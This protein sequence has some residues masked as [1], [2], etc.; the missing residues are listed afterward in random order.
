MNQ[1]I[2]RYDF[3]YSDEYQELRV[4]SV[5][6]DDRFSAV[7]PMND[8]PDS[9]DMDRIHP[10]ATEAHKVWNDNLVS[11]D[12]LIAWSEAVGGAQVDMMPRIADAPMDER[13]SAIYRIIIGETEVGKRIG[14]Q[15]RDDFD[16]PYSHVTLRDEV[17][18]A[19]SG[20]LKRKAIDKKHKLGPRK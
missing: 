6:E 18:H 8:S 20:A 1:E 12:E 4:V 19:M 9:G 5:N 2:G 17:A 10:I 13:G 16:E 11:V 3:V 15:V 14:F 7:F